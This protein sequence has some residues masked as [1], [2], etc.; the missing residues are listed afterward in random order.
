MN[1][2][3]SINFTPIK[4]RACGDNGWIRDGVFTVWCWDC[5]ERKY[6]ERLSGKGK[7]P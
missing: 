5:E 6:S 3:L 4:C 1:E 7:K 2:Q